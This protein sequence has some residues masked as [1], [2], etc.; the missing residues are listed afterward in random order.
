[1]S[2][3]PSDFFLFPKMNIKL[4]GRRFDMKK[5]KLTHR[6]YYTPNKETLP[7]CISKVADML[8][9]ACA[10]PRVLLWRWWCRIRYRLGVIALLIS[11]RNFGS[12]H[13]DTVSATTNWVVELNNL[14]QV[15]QEMC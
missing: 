7:G 3:V 2:L 12:H 9:S 14:H 15:T 10:L 1:L 4:K 8:G 5:F 11:F 6:R 13:V